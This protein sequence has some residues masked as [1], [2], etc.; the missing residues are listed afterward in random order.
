MDTITVP[1]NFTPRGYQ[2]EVFRAM[3]GIEGKP[4]TKVKRALLRWHRRAG[5]DKCCWCYLVKEAAQFSGNYFYIFPTKEMARR[6]VWE[7]IDSS[8]FKLLDHIPKELVSRKSNQEMLIE[9][10]NG[11]TIRLIGL[12]KDPDSIR[13]VACKGAVFSEFAFSDPEAYKTMIPALRESQGW[14]IFNSTPN[15]RNHFYNMWEANKS[16]PR[17]FTSH[18]QTY[19]PK[20]EGYTGLIPE[21]QFPFIMEEE[22]L[23]KEDVEREYGCSFS[24]GMK[25][26]FYV[27]QIDMAHSTGRIGEY[28]YDNTLPVDT[29]WDL[30]VDDSTAVW[31][32]QKKGNKLIFIDYLEDSG[33]ELQYYINALQAKGYN[34]GTHYLPHDAHQRSLQTGNTTAE[35]FESLCKNFKVSEDVWVLDRASVQHGINAVRTRFSRYCFDA[36]RCSEGITKL[37]LYHRRFDKKRQVYL[38]EPVHDG[39]S[40]AADALR[41]EAISEDIMQ[42]GFYSNNNIKVNWDFDSWDI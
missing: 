22:Q 25:G 32:R 14:V 16:S 26:S 18:I 20:A 24:T 38:K 34:Y 15:G 1:H 37:E 21:D 6:A 5:K 30:G 40:H 27:D 29:F 33:K 19:W 39:N 4:E 36:S 7:N 9:L 42:D 28:A 13:G 2:L 35:I 12:D 3:D 10:T 11:S 17:W 8:G 41:M 23:T 31:F